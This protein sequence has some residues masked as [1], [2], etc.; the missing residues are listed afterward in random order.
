MA[1]TKT[2]VLKKITKS[3][4]VFLE[5]IKALNQICIAFAFSITNLV[6]PE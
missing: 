2:T 1:A 4:T 3:L 5:I 6:T